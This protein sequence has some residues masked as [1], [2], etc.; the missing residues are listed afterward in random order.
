MTYKRRIV[1]LTLL[2]TLTISAITMMLIGRFNTIAEVQNTFTITYK[3]VGGG[4]FS[5]TLGYNTPTEHR[6][7]TETVL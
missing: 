7:G 2:M 6:Y 3:D 4:S 5:G 1:L